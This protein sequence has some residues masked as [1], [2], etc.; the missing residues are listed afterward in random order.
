MKGR[1]KMVMIDLNKWQAATDEQKMQMCK[2]L[3][4]GANEKAIS[5][6]DYILMFRFLLQKVQGE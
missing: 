1:V 3:A 4:D 6:D 2:A 5:K